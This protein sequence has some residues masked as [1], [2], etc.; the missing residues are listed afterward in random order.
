MNGAQRKTWRQLAAVLSLVVSVWAGGLG[1]ALARAQAVAAAPTITAPADTAP[2]D[3]DPADLNDDTTPHTDRAVDSAQPTRT[4]P[5]RL[6]AS[7]LGQSAPPPAV[8]V[9]A[10][11]RPGARQEARPATPRDGRHQLTRF[12]ILRR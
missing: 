7:V 4:A 3:T 5:P 8:A 6:R 10:T 9:A 12:C 11:T 1:Y 2:A